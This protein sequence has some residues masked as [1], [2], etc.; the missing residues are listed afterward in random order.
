[1]AERQE[2]YGGYPSYGGGS[3]SGGQGGYGG[4]GG[5]TGGWGGAP[6]GA[7]GGAPGG[8]VDQVKEKAQQLAGQA[9]EQAGQRVQSTVERGKT[10]A[11][12][13]LGGVAATLLQSSQQLRDQNPGAGQ[14][15]ERAAQQM[16]RLSD[17]LQNAEVDEIVERVEDVARRQPALFLG[18]L[19]AIGV[20]G[21]RFLKSSRRNQ[22]STALVPYRGD[23]SYAGGHAGSYASG[24]TGGYAGGLE[25]AEN[26]FPAKSATPETSPLKVN[27]APGGNRVDLV[28]PR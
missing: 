17:Y 19:F 2:N 8:T 4:T 6:S 14:Y 12:E 22:R 13:S 9:R 18:G 3:G 20:I 15:V 21:A 26:T 1:M 10:R 23:R 28:I 16:Q 24:S 25:K 7:Q 11:A 5:S 27:I